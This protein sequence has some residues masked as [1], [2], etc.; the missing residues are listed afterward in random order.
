MVI[1]ARGGVH[2]LGTWISTSACLRTGTDA[3]FGKSV[4]TPDATWGKLYINNE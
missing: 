3:A 1:L 2:W 4:I